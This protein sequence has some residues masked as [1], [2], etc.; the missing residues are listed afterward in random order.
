MTAADLILMLQQLPPDAVVQAFD[1]DTGDYEPVT[2]M[3]A[4]PAAADTQ[5]KA[6]VTLHT[7]DMQF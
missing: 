3:T 7:D 4:E 5:G 6:L 2:G 1:A